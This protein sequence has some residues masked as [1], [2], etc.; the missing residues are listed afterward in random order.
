MNFYIADLHLGH[1]N[2]IRLSNRPF[3]SVEEMDQT[4]IDNINKTVKPEDDLYILGDFAFNSGNPV[5]YLKQIRC[6]MHL[7]IGNHDGIMLKNTNARKYFVD[8]SPYKKISDNGNTVILFH[9]PI[10]EWDGYFRGSY[11][12][13]GHVHNNFANPWYKYMEQFDNCWNVGADVLDFTPVTLNQ[14]IKKGK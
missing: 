7:I 1:K 13:Y 6:K 9:Y 14:L 2:I 8:V 3:H 5:N 4:I 10:A 12:L 11:H